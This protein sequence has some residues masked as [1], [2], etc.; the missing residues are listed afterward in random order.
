MALGGIH[1]KLRIGSACLLFL[2]ALSVTVGALAAVPE[3]TAVWSRIE[4]QTR[5]AQSLSLY[6]AEGTHLEEISVDED[7]SGQTGLL[8]QGEYFVVSKE[9]LLQFSLDKKGT[10]S[11]ICGSATVDG[12]CLSYGERSL[13][14]LYITG[15]AAGEWEDFLLVGPDYRNRQVLRCEAGQALNCQFT[16]LLP[17]EY[18]LERNGTLVCSFT[19]EAGQ[20]RQ[21]VRLPAAR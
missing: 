3:E 18:R 16:G 15:K 21:C 6:N 13:T 9:G 12:H 20:V 17:G 10:L 2:I 7:G 14:T 5:G 4:L 8:T 1:M 19:V 11:L